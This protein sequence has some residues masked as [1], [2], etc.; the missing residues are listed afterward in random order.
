M[1]SVWNNF[2]KDGSEAAE[3]FADKM[4]ALGAATASSTSEIAEG[5]SKF[6]GIAD[7]IGL[8]FDYAT[9]ALATV[10]ATSRESADVVGTAFKTIFARMEGLKQGKT[11]ED[12]T[13]LNK[14]SEGL[15]KIGV[16][17]KDQNGA[18]KSMDEILD[19]VGDRWQGLTRDQKIATAQTVAGV[20]QYNQLMTLM[21]N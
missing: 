7:T 6:A 12:G 16:Q 9:S 15:A 21:D 17:I 5:L 11:D 8:S 20:R 10:T 1:T 4:T 13:D 3:S 14:Y 19:D 18:L 2:N